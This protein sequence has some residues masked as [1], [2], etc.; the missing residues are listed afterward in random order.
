MA[1]DLDAYAEG[2][3]QPRRRNTYLD[4]W[5]E[6][7][8]NTDDPG[9]LGG[10]W[11]NVKKGYYG[12]MR[13]SALGDATDE[14]ERPFRPI[15]P[16]ESFDAAEAEAQRRFEQSGSAADE[17]QLQRLSRRS[18]SANNPAFDLRSRETSAGNKQAFV[19]RKAGEVEQYTR[20]IQALPNAEAYQRW[21]RATSGDAW[22]AFLSDPFEVTSNIVAGS[23]SQMATQ[24]AI[25]AAAGF[26]GGA[27]GGAH[28]AAV[29]SALGAGLASFS[30]EYASSFLDSMEE[31]GIDMS[32]RDSI[33]KGLSDSDAIARA[34]SYAMKRAVPVG[35]F[36]M[37]S[38]GIAGKLIGKPA[39]TAV[40]KG[41][42]GAA[43]RIASK[44][45]EMATEATIQGGLGAAGE[46]T[47]QLVSKGK[48]DDWKSVAGEFIGEF[49]GAPGEVAVGAV[50]KAY[51]AAKAAMSPQVSI[52]ENMAAAAEEAE[53]A[54]SAP[55]DETPEHGAARQRLER[56]ARLR[57]EVGDEDF[58]MGAVAPAYSRKRQKT[59]NAPPAPDPTISPSGEAPF[60]NLSVFNIGGR[61]ATFVEHRQVADVPSGVEF[62]R[63]PDDAA[64]VAAGLRKYPQENIVMLV[65][66]E[67]GR[68]IQIARHQ[69]GGPTS[70]G[71]NPGILIGT[72]ASTPG[73]SEVWFI[74]NHPSGKSS[75][76]P[77][78]IS[79][80]GAVQRLT[81]AAGL[82]YR[83]AMAI[84]FDKY[85]LMD[86]GGSILSNQVIPRLPRKFSVPMTE[87]I[88]RNVGYLG[89][90]PFSD[91]AVVS[92]EMPGL[93][94]GRPGI[95]FA[96]NANMPVAA[97]PLTE[98]V[99][100]QMIQ[101]GGANQYFAALERSNAV[102]AFL[103]TADIDPAERVKV[104]ENISRLANASKVTL[105]DAIDAA[106]VTHSRH[107][108]GYDSL[109]RSR[110]GEQATAT[111]ATGPEAEELVQAIRDSFGKATDK[112]L[113][114]GRIRVV[115]SVDQLSGLHPDDTRGIALS[116]GSVEIAAQNVG[117]EEARG[118]VLH[119]VGVH[120]GLE[121]MVGPELFQH[122]L[123]EVDRLIAA[124]NEHAVS[125]RDSVPSDTPDS[126]RREEQLGYLMEHA[127][128]LGFIRK[129]IAAIRAWVYR[130][131]P[132][133]RMMSL[134]VGD[135]QSLATAAVRQ[136]ANRMAG[137]AT[138]TAAPR[139]SRKGF[140]V[141]QS[142]DGSFDWGEVGD[143]DA[144]QV[145]IDPG[146]I[147]LK[148]GFHYGDHRGFGLEHIEAQ[149]GE[150][151]R[152][153]GMEPA[154]FVYD[155]LR[156]YNN[157]ALQ[158]G[159]RIA[160][161]RNVRPTRIVVLDPLD[162]G[163]YSVRTAFHDNSGSLFRRIS[164]KG[165]VYRR[166]SGPTPPP[167]GGGQLVSPSG[168][169]PDPQPGG[170][171]VKGY[172]RSGGPAPRPTGASL[173]DAAVSS[174]GMN[175]PP[176]SVLDAISDTDLAAYASRLAEV[177]LGLDH[178]H[179]AREPLLGAREA[180]RT[181]LAD[182]RTRG[183]V[184][185]PSPAQS[186]GTV[187]PEPDQ[188]TEAAL[189]AIE[190]LP[191]AQAPMEGR[192]RSTAEGQ[193]VQPEG[194]FQRLL[195]GPVRF[196]RELRSNLPELPDDV[197]FNRVREAY[198]ALKRGTEVVVRDSQLAVRDVLQPILDSGSADIRAGL[199][200]ELHDLQSERRRLLSAEADNAVD[201]T[202]TTKLDAKIR[203]L[204]DKLS[205]D[206]YF[207]FT[208]L[209]LY[210]D[211]AQRLA[212][213]RTKEGGEITLPDRLTREEVV[214]R[215]R[216]W[217][218]RM[219]ASA[220]HAAITES[221]RRH[222]DLVEG[223]WQSL[224]DRGLPLEGQWTGGRLYFPHLVLDFWKGNLDNVAITA[225]KDF[226]KYLITPEGSPAFIETDYAKAMFQHIVAAGTDNLHQDTVASFIKPYDII[227]ELRE[228]AKELSKEKGRPISWRS[229]I[230]EGHVVY[231]PQAEGGIGFFEGLAIDRAE[232]AR[233][234]GVLIGEGPIN[235]ELRNAGVM[236][237]TITP[238]LIREALIKADE[239]TWVVP[240]E[241]AAA[242]D[243]MARRAAENRPNVFTIP[244]AFWKK[245][246]L[247][248]PHNYLRYEFNN[249]VS[250]IEKMI[251]A[252]PKV[253]A[254]VP[255]ALGEVRAFL[256][257][258]ADPTPEAAAAF[259][260][261]V[262][263]A[264]T[265]REAG[266][267]R[268]AVGLVELMTGPER[269]KSWLGDHSTV[270]VSRLREAS[271]RH[272]KFLAD[273]ERLRAG[274]RP[275]Y[276]G[277]FWR[278]IDSMGESSPGANDANERKAAAISLA[279]FGDYNNIS[280]SGDYLRKYW[281][282]FY[283]YLEN[284]FRYHAN[285]FRNLR[286]MAVEGGDDPALAT[287]GAAA[288]AGAA[289]TGRAAAGVALRLV[290]PWIAVQAWNAMGP[291]NDGL[292][293]D[294][295]D[296]DR[297]RF[298]VNLGRDDKGRARVMYLATGF[299]DILRWFGGNRFAQTGMDLVE[300]RT[301][302]ST[303]VGDFAQGY[304]ND[305]ANQVVSVG[306]AQK[307][308]YTVVSGKN[309][310]PDVANQRNIP[311]YAM[312][313]TILGQ[314]TDQFTADMVMRATNP[315]YYSPRSS[316]AWASQLVLQVRRRDPEQWAYYYIR[317]KTTQWKQAKTGVSREQGGY[318]SPDA[319][320]LRNFR[321]SIYAGDVDAAKRLYLRLLAYGYTAQRFEQGIKSSEPLAELSAKDG[322][323]KAFIDGLSPYDRKMLD[324]AQAYET[325]L[326]TL[327]VDARRLF[328]MEIKGFP[329]AT[330]KMIERFQGESRLDELERAISQ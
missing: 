247:F 215:L 203:E 300:G 39:V 97:L 186:T 45:G 277:A 321:R 267:I 100:K 281:I 42:M 306:P 132:G 148:D 79:A 204:N 147:M 30:G 238:D 240:K 185:I 280:V 13:A 245:W 65:T 223:T 54:R 98:E 83:G 271:F 138:A 48:V 231:R 291:G 329:A 41:I 103:Y 304:A 20:K 324:K 258:E 63:T 163:G 216:F 125:A 309:P 177:A 8:A 96:N 120:V 242:L 227:A 133:G 285:L 232:L 172:S 86:E 115:S 91:P 286:D 175:L 299:A 107:I 102:N 273:L 237:A 254:L 314:M 64:H 315:D 155:V 221:L 28:G 182:R 189:A 261:G 317:D 69:V 46:V 199:L 112:L 44:A 219:A 234:L 95:V 151:I 198:S 149:H 4:Q 2:R 287:A 200:S 29:G 276:G 114:L 82:K 235:A 93:L 256:S 316:W 58:G 298:H 128:E 253:L 158:D 157:I 206:P 296:E 263:D 35:V 1:F 57:A 169:P 110:S 161:I 218:E 197:R 21:E 243:G 251:A 80:S 312:A 264:P 209:V 226:R 255:R 323:R 22:T 121:A 220:H 89:Q 134:S 26:A 190:A 266:E 84:A 165:Q 117:K 246:T 217:K 154:E 180:A 51:G 210:R 109:F 70:A 229:L 124:G 162:G 233:Q 116:D 144:D 156:N 150:E 284:N 47:A 11:N 297:R 248:A 10:V 170:P 78:D 250:D 139:P 244:T 36:D 71:F 318:D 143:A 159:G 228:K 322:S 279:T 178:G 270:A 119:E 181:T 307:T 308:I 211:L 77:A 31:A 174:G 113:E 225:G 249:T 319:E 123:S 183:A 19:A 152:G 137:D 12:A 62:V 68:P 187:V 101:P 282:P 252:D 52:T 188:E 214:E 27:V 104:I 106:G 18:Y 173:A 73:A 326:S 196:F 195:Q 207:I 118:M 201:R 74:H 33:I 236:G 295:S 94:G 140:R 145:G 313:Q 43:R 303:A 208:N 6:A 67:N 34:K 55:V 92:Q 164:E 17:A 275:V 72:V 40:E 76:S 99:M 310:F 269:I 7:R 302:W 81:E 49:G 153:L 184:P 105:L 85:A 90:T 25:G 292:E 328:P 325:R 192:A 230:P 111:P 213:L 262:F 290:L 294:L 122:A 24:M 259:R 301:D 9:T 130:T 222:G 146:R 129:I 5:D 166:R 193:S 87:R 50:T 257:G 311:R 268:D 66:D 135:L 60:D 191:P 141:V 136:E 176:Q 131:I 320:A 283:T 278:D 53:K 14:Q 224:K 38:M 16:D 108:I 15:A 3:P 32:D 239:E 171:T 23:A 265:A 167:P 160:L 202:D 260:L 272:A 288:S 212:T 289:F 293:D 305:L 88:Y 330:K 327:K 179:P 37:L 127:P 61:L 56:E 59:K 142:P 168:A 274:G 241:V 205:G 194:F 75:L 126:M